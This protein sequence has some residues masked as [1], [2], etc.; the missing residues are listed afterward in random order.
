MVHVDTSSRMTVS[1]GVILHA[2]QLHELTA[3]GNRRRFSRG[4]RS[5]H[6]LWRGSVAGYDYGYMG[7]WCY[8]S[9]GRSG[10]VSIVDGSLLRLNYNLVQSC[11]P[12]WHGFTYYPFHPHALAGLQK[13]MSISLC[14][15]L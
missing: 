8:S 4:H 9:E 2:F 3:S 13:S 14:V 1:A 12:S 11:H 6:L 7:V 10:A 5:G 15:F